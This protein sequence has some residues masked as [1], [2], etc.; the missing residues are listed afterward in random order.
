MWLPVSTGVGAHNPGGSAFITAHN[1]ALKT[2]P[3]LYTTSN[4]WLPS[5]TIGFTKNASD[6]SY[7]IAFVPTSCPAAPPAEI[8]ISETPDVEP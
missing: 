5:S 2:K 4:S 8:S 1:A 6:G 7:S 3:A